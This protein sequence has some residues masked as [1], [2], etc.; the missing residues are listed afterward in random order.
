MNN[1]I[2]FK[3]VGYLLSDL[4]EDQLKPIK[5]EINIIKNDFSK[6]IPYNKELAGNLKKEY[7]LTECKNYISK[8]LLPYINKYESHFNYLKFISVNNKNLP[9]ELDNVWVNFQ[10]RYEFNPLHTHTGV[11]SFVIWIDIPYDIKD[12]MNRASSKNSNANIPGHFQFVFI[13]SMGDLAQE[14]IPA[15]KTYNGKLCIFPSKMNHCVY[16]FYTSQEY[17]ISVSGNFYLKAE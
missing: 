1:L 14:N 15:D 6:A 10:Q 12:E 9:L 4:T 2:Q 3:N 13:N 5:Q 8:L 17:R 7:K 11:Y 16:P